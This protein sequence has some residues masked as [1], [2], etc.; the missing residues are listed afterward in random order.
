MN[1]LAVLYRTFGAK[2][3]R[4]FIAGGSAAVTNLTVF[5]VCTSVFTVYYIWASILAYGISFFVSFTLQKFW[6]FRD[7]SLFHLNKQLAKYLFIMLFNLGVNTAILYTLVEYA[8]LPPLVAQILAIM[9]IAV[10]SFFVYHFFIFKPAVS[11]PP[12]QAE[13]KVAP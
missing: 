8:H 6:T 3:V 9:L 2:V 1:Y 12:V 5:Y 13:Q 10:W 11:T 4:F 7:N